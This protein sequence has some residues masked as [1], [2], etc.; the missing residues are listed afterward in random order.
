M[1]CP[2]SQSCKA[3]IEMPVRFESSVRL[4][5]CFFLKVLILVELYKLMVGFIVTLTKFL[6]F[7]AI[8]VAIVLVEVNGHCRGRESW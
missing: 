3:L 7:S 6:L 4:R 8:G 2:S 1:A 5:L